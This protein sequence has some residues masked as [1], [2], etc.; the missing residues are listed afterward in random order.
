VK[1]KNISSVYEREEYLECAVKGRN[2][3]S[4]L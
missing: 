4:V 1:E 3:S 2:I